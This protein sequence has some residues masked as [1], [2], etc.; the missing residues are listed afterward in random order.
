MSD[1]PGEGIRRAAILL[2]LAVGNLAHAQEPASGRTAMLSPTEGTFV[3]R[4]FRFKSGETLPETRIFY[5]ALGTPQ[6]DARG[7]ITNAVLM[8][9][10]T[11]GSGASFLIPTY[12]NGMFGAG[13]PL[14]ASRYYL[15]IPDNIGTGGSSKPSD[16]LRMKFPKYDYDDMV[17]SQYRLL[18]EH[19]K[20]DHLRLLMGTS[21]GCM[22]SYLWSIQHPAFMGATFAMACQPVEIA[23]LN[24]M[25]R[26]MMNDAIMN[27]PAWM[28]GEYKEQPKAGLA[29][30]L[31]M[32][33]LVGVSQLNFQQMYPTRAAIDKYVDD[34]IRSEL[35]KRDAN[36]VLYQYDASR[37]YDPRND[38]GK[39]TTQ[40][41]HVNT[42][43][44]IINPPELGN[45]EREIKKIKNGRFVLIPISEKTRGH[46]SYNYPEL[47][48]QYLEEMLRTSAN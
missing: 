19:L 5:R 15:I 34:Y 29:S 10:G 6:R 28:G 48:K 25:R 40:F 46:Q 12:M 22:H 3:M 14:N 33:A 17:E 1:Q 43:D 24:R 47:W 39:I 45:V 9:H 23:G 32:S 36:D 16:G 42:A 11:S 8:L 18:T 21:Q 7:H 2:A 26:K 41:L 20:V 13:Q 35:P 44:D 30:A 4:D 31:L 38:L 27:D 37:N